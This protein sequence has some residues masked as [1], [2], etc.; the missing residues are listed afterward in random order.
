MPEPTTDPSVTPPAGGAPTP[1]VPPAPAADPAPASLE[2]ALKE[3]EKWKTM[4]RRNEERAKS[5]AEAAT[6]LQ[7]IKDAQLSAEDK[8]KKAAEKAVNE[9]AAAK[10]ELARYKVAA[11]KGVPAELLT[12]SDE[13]TLNA[14]A[15]ALIAFAGGG[16]QT[17]PV[18]N[19]G[20]GNRGAAAPQDPNAWIRN[21][22]HR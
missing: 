11:A 1:P 20:Q 14:Q 9:A 6:E 7:T 19:L 12:G 10:A 8:A 2:D 3:V 18:P 5:N 4:S 15:D 16:Q 17:T 21:A 13:A 22:L